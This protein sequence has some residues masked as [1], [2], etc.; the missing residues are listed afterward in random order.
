MAT[1]TFEELKQLAIQI[2]DEKTN[3][4]NTATRIGTQMLEHINKLEQDY[5]DKTATD[6]ELK[7]RDEKL[8]ELSSNTG[9]NKDTDY[10]NSVSIEGKFIHTVYGIMD[11]SGN[12]ISIPIPVSKGDIVRVYTSNASTSTAV[13][14][15]CDENSKDITTLV[16]GGKSGISCYYASID[17]DG[18]IIVSCHI[19]YYGL[20]IGKGAVGDITNQ[21]RDE[22]NKTIED[23]N[24]TLSDTF[25]KKITDLN[26]DRISNNVWKTNLNNL[27]S[28][29]KERLPYYQ[30]VR[31]AKIYG[32]TMPISI[33]LIWNGYGA[34]DNFR[35]RII[36]KNDTWSVIDDSGNIPSAEI[37][38]NFNGVINIKL[39]NGE[40]YVQLSI[41]TSF[42]PK[43]DNTIFNKEGTE[44]EFIFSDNCYEKANQINNRLEVVVPKLYPKYKLPCVSFQFDD[45][46]EE[47]D[48][49]IALFE[50]YNVKCNFA[51][52]ASEDKIST[53]GEKY[54]NLQKRG[55]GICNHSIDSKVFNTTN[56][57]NVSDAINAIMT[58]KNKLEKVGFVVNG[59]VSPSS[60]YYS[61]ISD[62]ST[63]LQ[64]L[65]AV[66]KTNAYAFTYNDTE[67]LGRNSNPCRM[68]RYSLES[69]T[70]AEIKRRSLKLP[71]NFIVH[72]AMR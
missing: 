21:L 60:S 35:V 20:V 50:Q 29:T 22:T 18:Y 19:T 24:K 67:N 6:E 37:N 49:V 72:N 31:S 9:L 5:Y 26:I 43:G 65:E 58:A 10:T 51:F 64:Y 3:K 44:P 13:I 32:Y 46:V 28:V 55:Y 33:N 38:P 68:I 69:K 47:D 4:Q 23:S 48:Q 30:S 52:M 41:D 1:K 57:P 11:S 56:Y 2:R 71:W 25:N 61:D 42:I 62:E 70:I 63:R 40:N 15:K 53:Y 54:L 17:F 8:T 27:T 39:Q 12:R 14:S 7:Q 45:I 16:T 34:D 59:F 66:E 36:G